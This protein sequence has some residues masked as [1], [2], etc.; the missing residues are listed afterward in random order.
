MS[1]TCSSVEGSPVFRV[2]R[3][4]SIK[5]KD[6][7]RRAL[8]LPRR[9]LR[10][11]LAYETRPSFR[12][13]RAEN[14]AWLGPGTRQAQCRDKAARHPSAYPITK[15]ATKGRAVTSHE[16]EQGAPEISRFIRCHSIRADRPGRASPL[17]AF[18][19]VFIRQRDHVRMRV[20]TARGVKGKATR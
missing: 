9:G 20:E 2:W 6:H 3:A 14:T 13:P 10:H 16:R 8:F 1:P 19:I 11:Q 4:A 17:C 15:V 5:S 12:K 7:A 18:A